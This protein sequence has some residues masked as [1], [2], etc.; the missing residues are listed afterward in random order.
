MPAMTK[1]ASLLGRGAIIVLAVGLCACRGRDASRESAPAG[2]PSNSLATLR[3]KAPTP[4]PLPGDNDPAPSGP[5]LPGGEQLSLAERLTREASL[6]PAGA[7][8]SEDLVVAL[9][10]KGITV[11]RTRQVLGRTLNAQYCSMSVLGEGLVA[12]VCEYET[13]EAAAAALKYSEER[14]GRTI[15][16]RRLLTNGKSLLTIANVRDSVE[17]D[18]KTVAAAFSALNAT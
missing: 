1:L 3:D 10:A 14:F 18:V 15:P 16:N 2:D 7:V 12:S 6:R 13:P 17:N 11:T 8:R 4:P 9:K 5:A